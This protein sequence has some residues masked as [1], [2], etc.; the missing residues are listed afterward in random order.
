M[1]T[2]SEWFY[3]CLFI[4]LFKFDMSQQQFV[5]KRAKV[6]HVHTYLLVDMSIQTFFNLS[7]ELL[8][9]SDYS[10]REDEMEIEMHRLDGT[11]K[12]LL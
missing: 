2:Q 10:E 1:V 11:E 6:T 12:L 5:I 7:D 4:Y 9:H 3:L 8:S